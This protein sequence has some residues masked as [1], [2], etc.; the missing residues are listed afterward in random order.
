MFIY[1][2]N[3]FT[4]AIALRCGSDKGGNYVKYVCMLRNADVLSFSQ[5]RTLRMSNAHNGET[6]RARVKVKVK[7]SLILKM[8]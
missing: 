2:L 6:N 7:A 8:Q 4:Y 5:R 3:S 1:I